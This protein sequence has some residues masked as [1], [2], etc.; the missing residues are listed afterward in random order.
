[1]NVR[2]YKSWVMYKLWYTGMT[3]S[4]LKHNGNYNEILFGGFRRNCLDFFFKKVT[5][6]V[7]RCFS[8]K[9]REFFTKFQIELKK[10]KN[11]SKLDQ[12]LKK[13]QSSPHHFDVI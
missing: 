9:F 13:R 4:F 8:Y 10:R 12:V 7:K 1:M 2:Q 6:S 5:L 3:L 11:N